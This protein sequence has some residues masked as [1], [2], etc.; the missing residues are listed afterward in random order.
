MILDKKLIKKI[1]DVKESFSSLLNSLPDRDYF[2][3]LNNDYVE[4]DDVLDELDNVNDEINSLEK[5]AKEIL[6][7]GK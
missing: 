4:W 1:N 6:K 5:I 7:G 2:D 3:S